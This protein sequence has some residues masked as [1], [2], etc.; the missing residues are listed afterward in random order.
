MIVAAAYICLAVYLLCSLAF[1]L[2]VATLAAA[3]VAMCPVMQPAYDGHLPSFSTTRDF[4]GFN[5]PFIGYPNGCSPSAILPMK[6]HCINICKY[7]I[8][9]GWVSLML[10]LLFTLLRM[11]ILLTVKSMENLKS[12]WL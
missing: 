5:D 10:R 11:T 6:R 1:S 9:L 3:L 7:S 12:Y 4:E 2:V 8:T